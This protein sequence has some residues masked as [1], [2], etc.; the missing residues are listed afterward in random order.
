MCFIWTYPLLCSGDKE[1]HRDTHRATQTQPLID[2]ETMLP[3]R[4]HP[5][6]CMIMR[7]CGKKTGEDWVPHRAAGLFI[8]CCPLPCGGIV[9]PPFPLS[10]TLLSPRALA[11]SRGTPARLRVVARLPRRRQVPARA[12]E[13]DM[14]ECLEAPIPTLETTSRDNSRLL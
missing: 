10:P 11:C 7:R 12:A 5:L 1:A 2:S 8:R 14:G 6:K 4:A 3:F 13:S 9:A